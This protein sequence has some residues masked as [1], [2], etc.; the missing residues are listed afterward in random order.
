[1][2]TTEQAGMA[3]GQQPV[4]RRYVGSLKELVTRFHDPTTSLEEC[5]GLLSCLV[6]WCEHGARLPAEIPVAA[7]FLMEI[8]SECEP[9]HRSTAKHPDLRS[10]A[11]IVLARNVC[12]LLLEPW[13]RAQLGPEVI[14]RLTEF[15]AE[16][17]DHADLNA[18][19]LA[20]VHEVLKAVAVDADERIANAVRAL[21][22]TGA[23]KAIEA[24]RFY[25][26]IPL[27]AI[28]LERVLGRPMMT[29]TDRLWRPVICVKDS[30]GVVDRLTQAGL[31]PNDLIALE[32]EIAYV[33]EL[34][35]AVIDATTEDHDER[36]IVR[37]LFGLVSP[38][39]HAVRSKLRG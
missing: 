15:Y 19:D 18:R 5:H 3:Q 7:A 9:W 36:E 12:K 29:L 4:V 17:G 14:N 20:V 1:M 24:H 35:G 6:N 10:R 31:S 32:K 33:M 21:V 26:A 25:G 38:I 11:R 13:Q 30:S 23:W 2:T 8:G 39:F 16:H 22:A 37:V 28:R 27:L 34:C